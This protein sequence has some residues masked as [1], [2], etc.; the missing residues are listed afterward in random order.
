MTDMY[1]ALIDYG[2]I[3]QCL[4]C[5]S[6]RAHKTQ[7]KQSNWAVLIKHESRL[8]DQEM[9]EESQAHVHPQE[10]S[11]PFTELRYFNEQH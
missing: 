10:M 2:S 5:R 4:V 11:C 7:M 1:A 9:N 6:V 3:Q 8:L